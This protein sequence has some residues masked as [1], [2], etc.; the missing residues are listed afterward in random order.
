MHF[1][2]KGQYQPKPIIW[3]NLSLPTW[4]PTSKLLRLVFHRTLWPGLKDCQVSPS[5]L[6]DMAQA[7]AKASFVEILKVSSLDVTRSHRPSTSSPAA[8]RC[9]NS[10]CYAQKS[11]TSAGATSATVRNAWKHFWDSGSGQVWTTSS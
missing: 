2:R 1:C 11:M 6:L 8:A 9:R 5:T 4:I 7:Q 10:G 3:Q